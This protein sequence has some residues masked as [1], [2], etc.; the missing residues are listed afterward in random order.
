LPYTPRVC[1][2]KAMETPTCTRRSQVKRCQASEHAV[3]TDGAGVVAKQG[4]HGDLSPSSAAAGTSRGLPANHFGAEN[5]LVTRCH[6]RR[7]AGS[8]YV[9]SPIRDCR[10]L[11]A[12]RP[13]RINGA[14]CCRDST[15]LRAEDQLR[16]QPGKHRQRRQNGSSPSSG[17]RSQRRSSSRRPGRAVL[18]VFAGLANE[19]SNAP[20]GAAN[21]GRRREQCRH[22]T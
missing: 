1:T 20:E 8:H 7:R 12:G 18:A 3:P 4:I 2:F 19:A 16:D 13:T 22:E 5:S 21:R 10:R 14:Q 6:R 17:P 15:D 11:V 9:P